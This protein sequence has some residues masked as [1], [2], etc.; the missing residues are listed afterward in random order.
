[1]MKKPVYLTL[2]CTICLIFIILIDY[3]ANAA[4]KKETLSPI[5]YEVNKGAEYS[6]TEN[7]KVSVFEYGKDSLG[8]LYI[9]GSINDPAD[10]NGVKAY[11]TGTNITFGYDFNDDY[12]TGVKTAWNLSGTGL[13]GAKTINISG[14]EIKISKGINRGAIVVQKSYDDKSWDTVASLSD[15]FSDKTTGRDE[16]YTATE[17]ELKQGTFYRVVVVYTMEKQTKSGRFAVFG[18]E[19]DKRTFAE[20]YKIFLCADGDYTA[21]YDLTSRNE[22][23]F[24]GTVEA[25]FFIQKNGSSA[26][27][28]IQRENG[29]V[30][31]AG[32]NATFTDPGKYTIT[33]TTKLNKEFV[34]TIT[35]NS[36]VKTKQV[37]PITYDCGDNKGYKAEN[38]KIGTADCC[39]GS[40]LNLFIG[41]SSSK[42][43]I[44]SKYQGANAFGVQGNRA[45]IYA[46]LSDFSEGWKGTYDSWGKKEKETVDGV[47]TGEVG[48]G[49]LIIQKSKNGYEWENLDAGKYAKGLYTTDFETHYGTNGK[50]LLYSPSGEEIISGIFYRILYAYEV[51]SGKITK[52]YLE[53]Y[54]IYLCNA[55]TESVTFH[56][57]TVKETLDKDLSEVDSSTAAIYKG[58][59]SMKSGSL[60]TTG[61]TIDNTYNKTAKIS[62]K[63]NGTLISNESKELTE[64]GKYDITVTTMVGNSDTFTIYVDREDEE[65]IYKRYFGDSFIDGV[66]VLGNSDYPVF[67]AG[68]RT[69][70]NIEKV[71]DEYLPI[72]GTIT[73][74][75]AMKEVTISGTRSEKSTAITEAGEYVA[76]FSTNPSFA[77]DEKSGDNLLITIR[78]IVIEEGTAPGP[79]VN[80]QRLNDYARSSLSDAYPIF[81]GVTY[82]SASKGDITLAFATE[83]AAIDF[84][85]AYET[86]DA[87]KLEDGTFKYKGS[88]EDNAGEY[89]YEGSFVKQKENYADGWTLA[90]AIYNY[91]KQSVEK[92]YFDYGTLHS[93]NEDVIEA[94]SNL[95]TLELDHNVII[96]AD[97]SQKATLTD[98]DALPFI[99]N[100]P[101]LYSIPKNGGTDAGTTDFEFTSDMYGADSYEV[102]ITDAD[103]K[104]YEIEYNKS[105]GDQLEKAN[106]PS[107]IVTI[108]ET[109]KYGQASEPYEAV[110]I[111]NGDNT[112]VVGIGFEIDG[113]R[114][115]KEYSQDD[116]ADSISCDSFWFES[117][118]DELDPYGLITI[119]DENGLVAFFAADNIPEDKWV[120]EGTYTVKYKNRLGYDY[121]F[122]IKVNKNDNAIISFKGASS[123]ELST[124][125]ASY[126][127]KNVKLAKVSRY[128][129]DFDGYVDKDGIKYENE[130][131]SILFKGQLVLSTTWKPKSFV[132]TTIVKDKKEEYEIQYGRQIDLPK[133]EI[134]EGYEFEGWLLNGEVYTDNTFVLTQ[135]ENVTLSAL[136]R[137][138]S[139]SSAGEISAEPNTEEYKDVENTDNT[140]DGWRLVVLIVIVCAGVVVGTMGFFNLKRRN[141]KDKN[142][143]VE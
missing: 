45:E 131:S 35:V 38:I 64:T 137:K 96:F 109:T 21:A 47:V 32:E 43:V 60:T 50:I 59:E 130:I 62:V 140:S 40:H 83:K 26:T 53:E 73:N 14:Y 103:G 8:T 117:I 2:F 11:G 13:F 9:K 3:R 17:E 22:I 44:S 49:A 51:K 125:V 46:E 54:F 136:L 97:A 91:A 115:K 124:I 70:Y 132:L 61:F 126:G 128:G 24:P 66:R 41:H 18:E 69:K 77:T 65:A 121:S 133:P 102:I 122:K 123:D 39:S 78:F 72:Y 100:K 95:R 142:H 5:I 108:V 86:G 30:C 57:K 79:V 93:L 28:K 25:G 120:L 37:N 4:E 12:K 87:E 94:E 52:N 7:N 110:F 113:K 81:Y 71:S 139:V 19:Y 75:D 63:K 1:M 89:Q 76:I 104:K 118:K 27:V 135:E 141:R 74:L 42:D 111:A 143:E 116:C 84:A 67:E 15:A 6:F 85:Y 114:S 134:P 99:S 10:Y 127:D 98:L 90:D 138:I 20:V 107:G 82:K 34:H 56:N 119:S 16:L 58:A 80:K 23:S 106:C 105:V 48:T 29:S 55:S 88:Y 101:Y 92:S 68:P 33:V 31:Y 129:Y 112:G 36:G